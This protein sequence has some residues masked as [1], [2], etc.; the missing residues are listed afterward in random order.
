MD[1]TLPS[2]R[3]VGAALVA[4]AVLVG[5]GLLLS[6]SSEGDE[7]GGGE[8]PAGFTTYRTSVGG[9]DLRFSYPRSW[10]DVQ[11]GGDRTATTFEASGPRSSEDTRPFI[12]GRALSDSDASFESTFEVNKQQTRLSGGTDTEIAEETEID[13]PGAE[14][15]RLVEFRFDTET[16][17]GG[18]EPARLL[19]VFA[20]AG[21]VFV[22]FGAG[23]PQ[24]TGV[25]PRPIVE[26]L[27]LGE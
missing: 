25:D 19:A 9:H 20:K 5:G 23:A 15:A 14:E 26:S 21:N 18:T 12:Q 24:S 8:V 27:R 3:L 17:G 22:T 16:S 7:F 6:R 4:V 1:R 11:R 2:M 13:L 10:G